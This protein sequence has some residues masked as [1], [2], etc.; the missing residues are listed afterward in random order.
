MGW[1]HFTIPI[2]MSCSEFG[3]GFGSGENI[4]LMWC[5]ASV[6]L[7]RRRR[8][9]HLINGQTERSTAGQRMKVGGAG[10]ASRRDTFLG[11]GRYIAGANGQNNLSIGGTPLSLHL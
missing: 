11:C 4:A 10:R 1:A 3:S 2:V 9:N 7:G 6:L 8:R 5:G